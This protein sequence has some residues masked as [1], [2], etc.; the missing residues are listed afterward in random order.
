MDIQFTH[1]IN[2]QFPTY[3]NFAR[4]QQ[5]FSDPSTS[6]ENFI[7]PTF[8]M[9]KLSKLP[10]RNGQKKRCTWKTQVLKQKTHTSRFFPSWQ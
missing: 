5:L 10:S 6:N 1:I 2:L 4:K 3:I 9:K 8:S 7:A